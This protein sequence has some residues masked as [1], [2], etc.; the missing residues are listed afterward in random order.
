MADKKP[1]SGFSF[2]PV[3]G[4]TQKKKVPVRK[5]KPVPALRE[6]YGL[7][8]GDAV[9]NDLITQDEIAALNNLVQRRT[10]KSPVEYPD[11]RVALEEAGLLK[12][13]VSKKKVEKLARG[14]AEEFASALDALDAVDRSLG[15]A[16]KPLALGG[17]IGTKAIIEGI[18]RVPTGIG[19]PEGE[20][21][22]VGKDI[23]DA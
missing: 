6:N 4:G 1:Q 5:G 18:Q 17:V 8:V 19:K 22:T 16:I 15:E 20:R 3:I 23:G 11:R 10:G 9:E 21:S 14:G 7:G 12:P 13:T 2:R